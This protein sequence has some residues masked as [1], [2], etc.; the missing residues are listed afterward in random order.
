MAHRHGPRGKIDGS[1]EERSCE[2]KVAYPTEAAASAGLKFL[3]KERALRTGDGLVVY[4]CQFCLEFHF[5]HQR[6]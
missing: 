5:G 2:G 1:T 4:R 6:P 3:Q